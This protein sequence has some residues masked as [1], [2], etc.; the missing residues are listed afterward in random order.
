MILVL[1]TSTVSLIIYFLRKYFEYKDDIL[2]IR[3][4]FLN[5]KYL[6][7]DNNSISKRFLDLI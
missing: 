6:L 7:K 1:F 5:I 2:K 4:Q 3:F